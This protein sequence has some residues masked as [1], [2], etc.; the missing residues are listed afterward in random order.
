MRKILL[1]FICL[2]ACMATPVLA[3]PEGGIETPCGLDFFTFQDVSVPSGGVIFIEL[4]YDGIAELTIDT[5]FNDANG[6]DTELGLYDSAGNLIVNN[7]D[8]GGTL[9]SELVLTNLDAG[10][11]FVAVGT[12][13]TTFGATGFNA[14]S[15]G[16]GGNF[17]VDFNTAGTPNVTGGVY[18]VTGGNFFQ[19][20]GTQIGPGQVEVF[21]ID[22]DGLAVLELNTFFATSDTEIGLYD[23]FGFL[24]D[25][26][27]DAGGTLQSQ[28][29][30]EDLPAGTYYVAVGHFNTTFDGTEL[31][32]SSAS[33]I[34]AFVCLDVIT[35]VPNTTGVPFT[36]NGFDFLQFQNVTI[37]P[38][39]VE[40]FEI[41]YDGVAEL[42]IN[43][44]FND[45]NG[46][47]TELGLYDSFGNRI[48]NNDD[49][50]GTLQSEIVLDDLPA[51]TY[52]LA[53]GLFNTTFGDFDFDA[54]STST[55]TGSFCIDVITGSDD[56]VTPPPTVA[57]ID[58]VGFGFFTFTEVDP[59]AGTADFIEVNYDGVS[60]V[61]INTFFADANGFDTEIGLY[62]A[63]GNLVAANDDASSTLQSELVLK[64]LPAG[65]YFLAAST[66]NAT[67]NPGF[68]VTST[69]GDANFC[70]DFFTFAEDIILGDVNGDGAVTLLDVAPFVDALTLGTYSP[71]ADV[72]CDGIISLLDNAGFVSI[73]QGN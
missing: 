51:G 56:G 20:Q 28:L 71:E 8:A 30:V 16:P 45:A 70:V 9:Q 24:I 40:F 17:C 15:T 53:A 13:N 48:A 47:D 32:A 49:A 25:S 67:F 62:D 59:A 44:F 4:D 68:D 19:F 58:I 33:G 36:P 57:T 18:N 61:I 14:T 29:F 31:K 69:G 43:T 54:T 10:T 3:Q 37:D 6:I 65:T 42:T 50:G 2:I 52:Y 73:L 39:A 1:S 66:F 27:D 64:D 12:F 7:D 63:A 55:S 60:D 41:Q 23:E 46:N 26:N 34:D 38:M 22:Y 72:N 11:Y 35:S 5:F 21:Q